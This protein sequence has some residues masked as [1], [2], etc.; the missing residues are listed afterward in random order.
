MAVHGLEE[1]PTDNSPMISAAT[2]PSSPAK[3]LASV[4]I[5]YLVAFSLFGYYS[6][7]GSL[8]EIGPRSQGYHNAK[9]LWQ[10]QRYLPL[11]RETWLQQVTL[12]HSWIMIPLNQYYA[13][14]HFPVTLLFVVWVSVARR[15]QWLR[16]ASVLT[17]MTFMC[18][19]ID[20]LLPVAPPRLYTP[21]A[22]VD[23]LHRFGPDVYGAEA[24]HSIAD[25]YGAMPSLHFGWSVLVAWGVI[26]LCPTLG[27]LRWA[28]LLHPALTLAAVVLTGNHYWLDCIVAAILIPIAYWLTDGWMKCSSPKLRARLRKPLIGISIPLCLFGLFCV[29]QIFT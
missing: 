18:L 17:V 8:A 14:A 10:V 29:S 1:Q 11:P 13:F 26:A 21:L 7:A 6:L 12:P 24:V 25:Q 2:D 28:A 9:V 3:R 15:E 27:K 16:I 19:T 22:I 20:F 5:K 4:A 23:T